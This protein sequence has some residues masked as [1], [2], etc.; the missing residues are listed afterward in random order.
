[1]EL[2]VDSSGLLYGPLDDDGFQQIDPGDRVSVDA[3]ID[4][5]FIGD[6]DLLAKS[7]VTLVD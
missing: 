6:Q 2:S 1:M 7:V 4:R 3:V 5:D